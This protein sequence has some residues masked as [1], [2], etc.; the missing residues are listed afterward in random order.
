MVQVRNHGGSAGIANRLGAEHIEQSRFGSQ[1]RSESVR[2][3][4]EPKNL[5]FNGYWWG[6]NSQGI[7]RPWREAVHSLIVVTKWVK[8]GGTAPPTHTHTHTHKRTLTFKTL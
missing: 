7:K 4:L 5:P 2:P 1:Q 6:G 3:R 8:P